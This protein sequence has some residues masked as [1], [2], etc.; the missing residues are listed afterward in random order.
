MPPVAPEGS[1][2]VRL[3]GDYRL[4]ESDE[5]SIQIQATEY[6]ISVMI[7]QSEEWMKNMKW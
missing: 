1:F 7:T 2:D 6:P 3:S 5:V 4:T